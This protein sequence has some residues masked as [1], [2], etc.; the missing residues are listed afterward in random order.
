MVIIIAKKG[1]VGYVNEEKH[2]HHIID[3]TL[4]IYIWELE[5]RVCP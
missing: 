1:E 2:S 3:S 4:G 5:A